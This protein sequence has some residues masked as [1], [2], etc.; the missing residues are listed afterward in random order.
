ME[1]AA[2]DI[3]ELYDAVMSHA[4]KIARRRL[5]TGIWTN[6][7]VLGAD[8]F[9]KEGC[10]AERSKLKEYQHSHGTADT[11]RSPGEYDD[12]DDDDCI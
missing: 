1:K 3:P 7:S 11:T 2:I 12:D 9:L 4:D 6:K 8:K 10:R 5:G